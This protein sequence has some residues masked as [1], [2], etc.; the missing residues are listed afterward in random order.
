[1][2]QG[3]R[4]LALFTTRYKDIFRKY[5]SNCRSLITQR[6]SQLP[7]YGNTNYLRR[8]FA[9]VDGLAISTCL[10]FE[11]SM[12][13]WWDVVRPPWLKYIPRSII[14]KEDNQFRQNFIK[15][16]LVQLIYLYIY[17]ILVM[18][19]NTFIAYEI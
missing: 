2:Q 12:A 5:I 3:Y 9:F 1:M 13:A 19:L 7:F 11:I 8:D 18:L 6:L 15:V 17:L 4:R 14:V 10:S 16:M